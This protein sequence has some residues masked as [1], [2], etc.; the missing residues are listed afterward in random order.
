MTEWV[1][2][3]YGVLGPEA[4]ERKLKGEERLGRCREDTLTAKSDERTLSY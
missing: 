1:L 2:D 4:N 3:L